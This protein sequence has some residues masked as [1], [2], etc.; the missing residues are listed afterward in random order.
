[1]RG[2]AH[3]ALTSCASVERVRG[4]GLVNDS[5]AT[6]PSPHMK[7]LSLFLINICILFNSLPSHP[8]TAL[9][10]IICGARGLGERLGVLKPEY[11]LIPLFVR[12]PQREALERAF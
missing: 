12:E 1:M 7:G 4:R 3:P 11:H 5:P 2:R 8:V 9:E 6:Q 10:L